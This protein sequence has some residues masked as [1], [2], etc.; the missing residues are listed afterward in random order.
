MFKSSHS[1]RTFIAFLSVSRGRCSIYSSRCALNTK[2]KDASNSCIEFFIKVKI[3]FILSINSTNT[4]DI[5]RKQSRDQIHLLSNTCH[6]NSWSGLS[7]IHVRPWNAGDT[8]F[9]LTSLPSIY[10]ALH[11]VVHC[12]SPKTKKSKHHSESQKDCI[13]RRGTY[14]FKKK[15]EVD[16]LK[17]RVHNR[18]WN[19]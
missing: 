1:L 3:L 19:C 12:H 7:K 18:T 17:M 13:G 5:T 4:H 14:R 8:N 16:L 11:E 2:H 15:L 10:W 6:E 9:W